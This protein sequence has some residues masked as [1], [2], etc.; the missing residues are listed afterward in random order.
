MSPTSTEGLAKADARP[1]AW[2]ERKGLASFHSGSYQKLSNLL[3]LPLVMKAIAM[4][5][6]SAPTIWMY[7]G[8]HDDPGSRQRFLEE[9]AKR[10]TA[11]HFV[12]VEWEQSVFER[13]AAWRP[14]IAQELGKCW[15]F[16]T[17][18]ECNGL[19][20]AL[21]WEGDAYTERFPG[22]DVLWLESGFQEEKL[23][24]QNG[25][26]VSKY[27]EWYARGVCNRLCCRIRPCIAPPALR[28]EQELIDHVSQDMWDEASRG[29]PSCVERDAR[30]A[31]AIGERSAGL[32]EGWIAVVVGWEHADPKGAPERLRGLLRTRGFCV[33]S[34]RLGP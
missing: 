25:A 34:V 1:M 28:S 2:Y 12:A 19:S 13:L 8:V 31:N 29:T 23:K 26:H 9:L 14:A 20:C 15:D 21:A 7:G 27:P 32:C 33:N 30:W 10:E 17:P 3:Y 6:V 18:K 11:P 5:T 22:T 16:L 4:P 24:R